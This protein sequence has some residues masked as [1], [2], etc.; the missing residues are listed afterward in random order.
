LNRL[1][2]RRHDRRT[3]NGSIF[4]M[5]YGVAGP[6]ADGHQTARLSV[7]HFLFSD[8]GCQLFVKAIPGCC[9]Q[10]SSV[11]PLMKR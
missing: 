9:G 3:C 6:A 1:S 2:I 4:L 10:L 11:N 7:N 5:G 8:Q